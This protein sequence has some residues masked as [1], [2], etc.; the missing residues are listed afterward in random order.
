MKVY[1]VF[2]NYTDDQSYSIKATKRTDRGDG[3]RLH[4]GDDLQDMPQDNDYQ[5]F[6]RNSSNK[7][8]LIRHFNEYIRKDEVRS[9]LQW[10][11]VVTVGKETWEISYTGVN[12]LFDSKHEKADSRLI[13]HCILDKW[14]VVVIAT[15]S[16]ILMCMVYAFALL[17]PDH[18]WLLQTSHEKL[19]NIS[20]IYD[21]FCNDIC[22]II[23]LFFV[24]TG[25][26]TVSFF[27]GKQRKLYSR[28]S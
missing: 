16:D 26:D 1:I 4:I 6:L 28:E 2:D 12:Y 9:Q 14:P 18:D 21:H 13:Y 23:P 8:E 3:K 22:L 17:L 24:L 5:D 15:D 20:K 19:V 7:A 10:P 27:S 25:C 11:L